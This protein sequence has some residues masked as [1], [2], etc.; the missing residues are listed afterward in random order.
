MSIET[1]PKKRV[2]IMIEAP[3]L[4]RVTDALDHAQATG[5]TVMPALA[6]RGNGGGWQ[7]DDAF[8]DSGALSVWC[9]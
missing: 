7:R 8:G 2:E 1:H 5:Y 9:A 3:A 6:G 4:T